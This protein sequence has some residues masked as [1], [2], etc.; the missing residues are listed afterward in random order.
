MSSKSSSSRRRA[1]LLPARLPGLSL[2]AV[3]L[4]VAGC[5]TGGEAVRERD[6]SYLFDDAHFA[7]AQQP[8]DT[9]DVFRMTPEMKSFLERD[10]LPAAR[11]DGLRKVLTEALYSHRQLRLEYEASMTRTAGEAFAARS[12]N[13]LSLVIMTGTFAKAMGLVVTYQSVTTDEMWSRAG[14]MYFLS[15][16][17]N[18]QIDRR[19]TEASNRWDRS[20]SYTIDFMPPED[21]AGLHVH[22]I[23]ERTVVAMYL[24]NRAAEAML[25]G[26]LDEAYWRARQAILADPAFLSA[27]NTL[28]VIYLRHA[29]AGHAE[30]AFHYVIDRTPNNSR[31]LFNETQALHELGRH[32]EAQAIQA[33]LAQL[34]PYPPFY[35]FNRGRA[36]IQAGDLDTARDLFKK[37]LARAPDYHEFHYWLA[38]ADFGLGRIDEARSELALAMDDAV[39]RSDHDLYAAKLDRLKAWRGANVQ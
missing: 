13:C 17:V 18:L 23:S 30:A 32:G 22:T 7:A 8:I 20:S 35:F 4:L 34:E 27:Y 5:A 9:A 36:A 39:K 33:R 19:F 24:N 28:G 16:H 21:A 26:Q 15:G 1:S 14:D 38:I 37:E 3:A 29:D 25:H 12:G 2:V 11:A 31:V 6:V 10:L